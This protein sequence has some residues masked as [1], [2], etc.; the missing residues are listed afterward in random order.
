MLM[1]NHRYRKPAYWSFSSKNK[2]GHRP[3]ALVYK[4]RDRALTMYWE[5]RSTVEIAVALD[6]SID[7][8]RRYI[9][10]GRKHGDER[11]SRRRGD[12][13]VMNANVRR[14]QIRE[15]FAMGMSVLEIADAV[16]C[17]VRLVQMRLK[18]ET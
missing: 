18:E 11:A 4:R 2:K 15:L 14:R 3:H 16:G 17:H 1:V 5:Q 10:H 7:T 8:V 6:V 12:K 9:M 13:Q